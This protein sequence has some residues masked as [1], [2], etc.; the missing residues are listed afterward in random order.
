M[1]IPVIVATESGTQTTT[2]TAGN[3]TIIAQMGGIAMNLETQN[4]RNRFAMNHP[5]I[6]GMK[7]CRQIRDAWAWTD[8]RTGARRQYH[9]QPR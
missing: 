6:K 5:P 3:K 8:G 7:N 9:L 1:M 4:G 2:K